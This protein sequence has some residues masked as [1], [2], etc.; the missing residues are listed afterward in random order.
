MKEFGRIYYEH[1]LYINFDRNSQVQTLFEQNLK[2]EDV[3]T[4]LQLIAGR[5]IDAEHTLIIFDEVQ[6]VPKALTAVTYS[7]H[8]R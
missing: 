7:H 2:M 3:L 6:E 1:T 8:F 4:G 5:K